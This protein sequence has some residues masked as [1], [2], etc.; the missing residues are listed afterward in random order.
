MWKLKFNTD[1]RNAILR[2]QKLYREYI[3][4]GSNYIGFQLVISNIGREKASNYFKVLKEK[5]YPTQ[6]SILRQVKK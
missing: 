2:K 1:G 3:Q 5:L 4:R 6:N